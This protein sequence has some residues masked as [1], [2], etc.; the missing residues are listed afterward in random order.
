MENPR[1]IGEILNQ[2]KKIE[3][4]NFSNMEH[5]TSISMLLNSSE[6]GRTKDKK[7]SAKF[8][9]LTQQMEDINKL[10]SDL[11]NDLSSRYN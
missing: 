7:L 4:N 9:Q 8:N 10:T 3:E 2:A 1:A 11:L 5:F 6:L